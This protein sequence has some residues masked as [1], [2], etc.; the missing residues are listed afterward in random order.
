MIRFLSATSIAAAVT[1]VAQPDTGATR[2]RAPRARP[3]VIYHLPPASNYAATLHSQA[4][5]QHNELPIDG[6]MPASMQTSHANAN[7]EAAQ[8]SAAT[9][10][11]Q[12]RQLK[13][14]ARLSRAQG[15]PHSFSK[16]SGRGNGHGNHSHKK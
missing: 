16:S 12:E 11:P 10:P 5:N 3:Q 6:S 4:K 1:V 8:Q 2:N 7:T 13:P 15:R 14:R 9:Q